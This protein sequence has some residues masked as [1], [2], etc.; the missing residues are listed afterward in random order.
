VTAKYDSIGHTYARTRN[1]D[2][3]LVAILRD[4]LGDALVLAKDEDV[5][6]GLAARKSDLETGAWDVSHGHLR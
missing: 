1:E 5:A 4:A 2:P 3:R 6:V